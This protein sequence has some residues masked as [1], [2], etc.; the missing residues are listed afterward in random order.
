MCGIIITNNTISNINLIDKKLIKR[1]PDC[2]NIVELNGFMFIHYLLQITGDYTIQ[3]FINNNIVCLYNGEIYNYLEIK[4]DAKSDGECLI[5]AY[6]EYGENFISKLDGEFCIVLFDFNSNKLIIS[7]D[8]FRTKP[9]YYHISSS[10]IIISSYLSI[11]QSI[12]NTCE[13]NIVNPNETLIYNLSDYTLTRRII[14]NWDL[15]QH[16][17]DLND[18]EIAFENAVLKRYSNNSIISLS[19]GLDSGSIVCCLNKYNKDYLALSI[20]INENQEVLNLRKN[21]LGEKF[22]YVNYNNTKKEINRNYLIENCEC[23]EHKWKNY[24]SN[25]L[26]NVGAYPGKIEIFK[27]ANSLFIDK[28]LSVPRVLYSGIGGDE[29]MGTCPTYDN[30]NQGN[31]FRFTNDLNEIFP[32]T[33]FYEGSLRNYLL[34]DEFVGG[35][36]SY[37]NRYPF[38]DKNLVQEFLWLIPEIKNR[39]YKYPLIWYLEKY[40]FP[41]TKKKLGFNV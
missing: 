22:Y 2:R 12:N 15:N 29:I 39:E 10:N 4:N 26:I 21:I 27:T 32:W 5:P 25:P 7:S 20:P 34:S 13:Y 37:E 31:P 3:P 6:I 9:L 30:G 23:F 28:G 33:N 38:L 41:L 14:Y 16:K 19:S 40:N 8:I 24:G 18:W 1:G 36:Y 11:C 35:S 17:H